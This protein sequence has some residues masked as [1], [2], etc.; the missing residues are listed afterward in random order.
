LLE[1]REVDDP[2]LLLVTTRGTIETDRQIIPL[3]EMMRYVQF[4]SPGPN[5]LHATIIWGRQ[6]GDTPKKVLSARFD[7]GS[8]RTDVV[9][10][11]RPHLDKIEEELNEIEYK[12]SHSNKDDLDTQARFNADIDQLRSQRKQYADEVEETL[13]RDDFD[14]INR[15]DSEGQLE[16]VVPADMFAKKPP[17]WMQWLGTRYSF[18]NGAARDQCDLKRRALFTGI[19]GPFALV[20]IACLLLVAGAVLSLVVAVNALTSALLLI[21]GRRGVELGSLNPFESDPAK[22]WRRRGHSF[23][24]KKETQ[25]SYGGLTYEDRT[26]VL[27]VLNPTTVVFAAAV[28]TLVGWLA[29]SSIPLGIAIAIGA[30]LAISLI[31]ALIASGPAKRKFE[32]RRIRHKKEEEDL[33]QREKEALRKDLELLACSN[34]SSEVSLKALPRERRTVVLRFHALKASVCKPFAQ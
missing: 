31:V 18:W 7:N 24:Y 28:G 3:T 5:V 4:R 19:S 34:Q 25:S 27:F 30:L 22:I 6:G 29:W 20:G 17:A 23:W 10:R 8:Y 21:D 14:S 2:Q 11:R 16:V 26:P 13:I 32:E 12:Q 9:S 1:E 15:L 33:E